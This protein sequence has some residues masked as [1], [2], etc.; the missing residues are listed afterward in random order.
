MKLFKIVFLLLIIL[1]NNSSKAQQNTLSNGGDLRSGS[2]SVAFSI[3]QIDYTTNTDGVSFSCEGVQQPYEL[4]E[5]IED[6]NFPIDVSI[7]PNPSSD[8]LNI[9]I[10]NCCNNNLSFQII[11]D[12]G[13][14]IKNNT[15]ITTQSIVSVKQFASSVYFLKFYKDGHLIKTIKFLKR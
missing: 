9:R 7:F 2:G 8:I 6:N 11:D 1:I 3:G 4:F 14:L 5:C 13:R 15:S 12:L 10:E